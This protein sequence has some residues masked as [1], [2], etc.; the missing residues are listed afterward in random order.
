MHEPIPVLAC[1][2][3]EKDDEGFKEVPEV[4]VVIVVI[5]KMNLAEELNTNDRK[6][7]EEKEEQASDIQNPR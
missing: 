4:R 2:K 6:N 3:P 7:D 5:N 1:G